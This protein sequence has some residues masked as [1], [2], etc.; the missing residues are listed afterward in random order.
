MPIFA[1]AVCV[2]CTRG[3][4]KRSIW[5]SQWGGKS[6]ENWNWKMAFII[7]LRK[8]KILCKHIHA[9][10]TQCWLLK[11]VCWNGTAWKLPIYWK[12]VYW[13]AHLEFPCDIASE[14]A[15]DFF[16]H[17]NH[18]RSAVNKLQYDI[19][20]GVKIL[21]TDP[22]RKSDNSFNKQRISCSVVTFGISHPLVHSFVLNMVT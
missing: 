6:T 18:K 8:I 16:C 7:R 19:Q 22:I 14:P 9:E 17:S 20:C 1:R 15:S 11:I 12:C 10:Q 13:M 5:T 3:M 2:N 4:L 21:C